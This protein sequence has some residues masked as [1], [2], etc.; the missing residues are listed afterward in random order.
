[1]WQLVS[2]GAWLSDMCQER[3]EVREKKAPKKGNSHKQVWSLSILVCFLSYAFY[4]CSWY[5]SFL[6]NS[7]CRTY[8][9]FPRA[10]RFIPSFCKS[11]I[12]NTWPHNWKLNG[13]YWDALNGAGKSIQ[14]NNLKNPSPDI[15]SMNQNKPTSTWDDQVYHHDILIRLIEQI[16][17]HYFFTLKVLD[18]N[19]TSIC[20]Y[21]F[22]FCLMQSNHD[23]WIFIGCS[24]KSI[25]HNYD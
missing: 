20:V 5:M 2:P 8:W 7:I 1:M 11:V 24:V 23:L 25:Q 17:C 14:H 18:W 19:R 3:Y 12:V 15:E 10:N 21:A 13:D 6:K 16:S 22:P 9:V 4:Y